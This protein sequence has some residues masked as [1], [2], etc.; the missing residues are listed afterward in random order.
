MR[1]MALIGA[2]W[3]LGCAAD[4]TVVNDLESCRKELAGSQFRLESLREQKQRT[5]GPEVKVSDTDKR[6]EGWQRAYRE[7]SAAVKQSLDG[8][9]YE[10]FV[11]GGALV[12]LFSVNSFFTPGSVSL[13]DN[14]EVVIDKMSSVLSRIETRDVLVACRS[15]DIRSAVK[16]QFVTSN[17]TLS[18]KRAAVIVSEFEKQDIDPLSLIAAGFGDASGDEHVEEEGSLEFHILPAIEELPDYSGLLDL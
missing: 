15:F 1:V 2:V 3:L 8:L 16:T 9:S 4:Q 11:Q 14:G 17:R 6:S 5:P 7:V 18:M 12:V 10:M 13:T